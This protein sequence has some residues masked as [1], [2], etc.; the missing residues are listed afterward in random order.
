MGRRGKGEK[1]GKRERGEGESEEMRKWLKRRE[2][3][4]KIVEEEG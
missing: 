1:V 4:E 2:E 3:R